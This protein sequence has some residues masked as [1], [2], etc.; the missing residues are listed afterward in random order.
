MGWGAAVAI[1][2]EKPRSIAM[3]LA[4]FASLFWGYYYFLHETIGPL[5]I[6]ELYFAHSFWLLRE[7]VE[8][9]SGFYSNHLPT[10]F[11]LLSPLVPDASPDDLRFVWALRATGLAV[12]LAYCALLLAGCRRHFLFLLP[13]LLLFL[14]FGRMTEIRTDTA[15]L[16]LFNLGWWLLL[17]G[18]ERRTMLLAGL[19]SGLALFFSARA[20]VMILGF[21][22]VATAICVRRRDLGTW[23]RLALVALGLAAV[24]LGLYLA[25]PDRFLLAIRSVYLDPTSLMPELSLWNRVFAFDRLLLL[26]MVLAGLAGAAVELV[27][28]GAPDRAI[29]IAGACATQVLLVL[30]DPSPYQYV[31]GWAALPSLAGIAL[32]GRRSPTRLQAALAA[33]AA[34]LAALLL[35]LS[36][37]YVAANRRVPPTG[38]VLRISHD[39][40]VARAELRRASTGQLVEKMVTMEGQQGLWNQLPLLSE[41]CRRIDGPV[42]S[43]FYANPVCLHD[44]RRDW[45]GLEWLAVFE[46]R[47]RPQTVRELE[48]LVAERPP[49]LIAWGKQHHRPELPAGLRESLSDY[50]V[51]DGFALHGSVAAGGVSEDS[52][53][54]RG[55]VSPMSRLNS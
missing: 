29:V 36:T 11:A 3:L 53:V 10:Y 25:A 14:I 26:A 40:P 23:I 16:L 37:A 35:A 21:A 9:Y 12:A 8:Q 31:Y 24:V 18:T 44:A 48:R 15:G 4:L 2:R 43:T 46:G 32:L 33:I 5:G 27:R 41:I 54:T 38:S 52:R 55:V 30:L 42:L 28:G 6:D 19:C 7:G 17:R 34:G 50:T 49:R 39:A 13:F 45:P 47:G 20:A 51:Y 22:L 1:E